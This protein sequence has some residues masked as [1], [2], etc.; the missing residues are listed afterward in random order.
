[1]FVGRALALVVVGIVL[2][3][4]A[5]HGLGHIVEGILFGIVPS[6]PVT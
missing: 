4:A 3:V 6:E 1:M 5:T 2:G